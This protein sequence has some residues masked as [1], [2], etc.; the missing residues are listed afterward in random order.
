MAKSAT[1]RKI[2]SADNNNI[3]NLHLLS[4]IALGKVRYVAK[5]PDAEVLLL[6]NPPLIEINIHEADPSDKSKVACR[7]TTAG[8]ALLTANQNPVTE[9]EVKNTMSNYAIIDDA[10][11]PPIKRGGGGGGAPTKYPFD[12]LEVGKSFFV[13]ATAKLPNP[14]KTL[15]S[16]I[17][18]A[19]HRY[20]TVTGEKVV[21]RSKRGARNKLVLDANGNKIM[22]TKTVPTYEFTRK[23]TIRG[24]KAGVKYGNWVAPAD[25]AL[26]ARVR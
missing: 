25:G 24:V 6:H 13:P 22:E 15:G 26:I 9:N 7:V 19:N 18:S 21:E 16:T 14:L 2:E 23:F 11:L 5:T 8:A 17:S 4:E 20:A 3:V 10:E 12:Q 1:A